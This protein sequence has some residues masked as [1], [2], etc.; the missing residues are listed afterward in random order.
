MSDPKYSGK[1]LVLVDL[2]K[3]FYEEKAKVLIFSYSTTLLRYTHRLTVVV[4]LYPNS[5]IVFPNRISRSILEAFVQ[6]EGYEYRRLDGTT[7]TENRVE[8]VD[9]FNRDQGIF[10]FLISTRYVLAYVVN[11]QK[12]TRVA[13]SSCSFS[14][15]NQQQEQQPLDETRGSLQ[16]IQWQHSP[17]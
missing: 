4:K 2:L 17:S 7:P 1:M 9:E 8:M 10:L 14:V 16:G 3:I 12:N 6:S 11:A 5:I 13:P 15:S